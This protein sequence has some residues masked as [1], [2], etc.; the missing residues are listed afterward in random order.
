M[1]NWELLQFD[2]KAVKLVGNLGKWKQWIFTFGDCE[3]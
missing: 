1:D 3:I 2:K